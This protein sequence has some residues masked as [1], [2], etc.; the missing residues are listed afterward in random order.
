MNIHEEIKK[1]QEDCL[2]RF[3]SL[4]EMMRMLLVT[5]ASVL[6]DEKAEVMRTLKAVLL[7]KRNQIVHL[8]FLIKNVQIKML[9]CNFCLIL[10]L[11]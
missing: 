1:L 7:P 8:A 4:D 6:I 5:N 3:D 11:N 9:F 2:H 10:V